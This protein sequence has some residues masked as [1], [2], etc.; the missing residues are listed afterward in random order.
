MCSAARVVFLRR[1]RFHDETRRGSRHEEM[2]LC[3]QEKYK[4]IEKP[5]GK[6]GREYREIEK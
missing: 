6:V 1:T 3:G 4:S 2:G 5:G